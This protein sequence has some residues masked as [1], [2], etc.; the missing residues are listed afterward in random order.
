M[1]Y[2]DYTQMLESVSDVAFLMDHHGKVIAVNKW[3]ER[4]F[5]RLSLDIVGKP[6]SWFFDSSQIQQFLFSIEKGGADAF[7]LS[8]DGTSVV[9]Q[10]HSLK[11]AG[12]G[13]VISEDPWLFCGV[14]K[15]STDNSLNE[16]S[17]VRLSSLLNEMHEVIYTLLPDL[18]VT[19]ISKNVHFMLGY[20]QSEVVGRKFIDFLDPHQ[21][22]NMEAIPWA[23]IK[24]SDD[25]ELCFLSKAGKKVW[26]KT[27]I[28]MHTNEHGVEY[29]QGIL[30]DITESKEASVALAAS[31][32][33]YRLLVT[34]MQDGLAV[35][36][37][38]FDSM[39][40]PVDYRFLEV[41]DAFCRLTGL[42][43]DIVG[44][45]VKEVM[46]GV[47]QIWIHRYASVAMT[48]IPQQFE[49]YSGELK[50]WF[51]VSA[52]STVINQFAVILEEI[53]EQKERLL[54]V[55]YLSYH[56]A[57]TGL[58]NRHFVD[59][60]I[61]RLDTQRN[62]PLAYITMDLNG[63]K[64]INDTHGHNAGDQLLVEFSLKIKE[65]FR[66]DDI[67]GRMGGDEFV[68]V[69]PNTKESD[70]LPLLQRIQ[71][72]RLSYSDDTYVAPVAYGFAI[73]TREDQDI[74]L[75]MVE[76]DNRMYEHK[77][78]MKQTGD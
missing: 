52:Y 37:L 66:E 47:E 71:R 41:N 55:E 46:P 16:L 65:V 49:D 54:Q 22:P 58:Y 12:W 18:T 31:E 56:D 5:Q 76:A 68:V 38:V 42:S 34:Q 15:E 24:N 43:K 3:F 73:K 23:N 7:Y 9:T 17:E 20:S 64:A 57:L 77:R 75:V 4:F 78:L 29:S 35:H 30:V 50:K 67:I 28:R 59:E 62:Y 40:Q 61:R 1:K 74:H 8:F 19:Y 10:N 32:E 60:S 48:Q 6:F 21:Y 69:L 27:R 13:H 70:V 72:I 45:T 36:K 33:R 44:K 11:L 14:M 39:N 51:R 25:V 2:R 53:T 63:L 26:V